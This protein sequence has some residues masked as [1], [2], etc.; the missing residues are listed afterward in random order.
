MLI[1]G[2][3]VITFERGFVQCCGCGSTVFLIIS[4]TAMIICIHSKTQFKSSKIPLSLWLSFFNLVLIIFGVIVS[5][6][7]TTPVAG[8]GCVLA[9]VDP[10][11]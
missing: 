7:H 2:D 10:R 5:Q 9:E 11:S 3:N 6:G 8:A 1:F 4:A